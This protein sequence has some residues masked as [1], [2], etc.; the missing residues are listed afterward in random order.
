MK[1]NSSQIMTQVFQSEIPLKKLAEQS[2]I[3]STVLRNG[4][5]SCFEELGT[6]PKIF[7]PKM[8]G[9]IWSKP[10]QITLS[11]LKTD[12]FDRRTAARYP[13]TLDQIV[14]GAFSEANKDVNDMPNAALVRAE[15]GVLT[16][17]GGRRLDT[18]WTFTYPFPCQKPVGQIIIKAP[19]MKDVD[20]PVCEQS[21]K[22]GK[23]R[24]HLENKAGST[25]NID[26]LMSMRRNIIAIDTSFADL[27]NGLSFRLYRHQ[28]QGHRRYMDD[29]GNYIA[30]KDR[31]VVFRPADPSKPFEYYDLEADADINGPFEPPKSGMDGRFFWVTQKF[32]SEKTFPSGFEYVMMGLVS[33]PEAMINLNGLQKDLGSAPEIP[34]NINGKIRV[35]KGLEAYESL[36]WDMEKSYGYVRNAYGVAATAKLPNRGEKSAQL[37]ITVVTVNESK[38]FMAEARR[39]LLEAERLGFQALVSENEQWYDD[40]YDRREAGR[41]TIAATGAEKARID[42]M[43]L[44]D[45]Y[46]S[47]SISD[48]GHCDPDPRRYEGS[49]DYATFDIDTQSWHSLPCYNEIFGEPMLVRNQHER[50]LYYMRLLEAW[51]ETLKEKARIVYGLPGM[52]F[53]HGYLPPAVPDPWY[54]ECQAMDLC[55]DVPGQVVKLLWSIWDYLGDEDLLKRQVY[56]IT[57][58]LAIFYEAFARRNFDGRFYNLAPVVET[59]NWGISYHLKHTNNTTAAL[60]MFRKILNCAIEGATMLN[61]DADLIPGWREVAD[62]LAPYPKF[63]IGS[64]EIL[65]GNPGAMPRWAAGDHPWFTGDYPA[66]LADEINLDSHQADK[67]LIIRTN[68]TVRT[69]HNELAYILVGHFKDHVPCSY[70][71]P[72]VLID[73]SELLAKEVLSEKPERLL[74]S[75]SGRI[76]LFPVVPDWSEVAFRDMLTRGGFAVS[77]AK[78]RNGVQAVLIKARRNIPC[79]VMNP[80]A[81]QGIAGRS[82]AV[83]DITTGQAV[84]FEIDAQN[85]ECII[86]QALAGHEYSLDR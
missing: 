10:H 31:R 80:W 67:D 48:G 68:D 76:H 82:I 72:A 22:N 77:A 47:W 65:A 64:G 21:R 73:S 6:S 61:V 55:L 66:T 83:T 84:P 7:T 18:A 57:R 86:F 37:Y 30:K 23:A 43:V 26:Y 54:M 19:D 63:L 58:D 38:D 41:I 85:G 5:G 14:K 11:L 35:D 3:K 39:Q 46:W 8:K 71:N 17:E 69:D 53:G 34:V 74:N 56:P 42:A 4:P 20:Q 75:R 50:L 13:T 44:N 52:V 59:E 2:L 24:I 81:S 28:D 45:A 16:E 33:D 62:H 40:L 78:D 1:T 12:V 60:T 29:Q 79:Q 70:Y 36:Y 25:L 9:A 49:E 32:P 51:H 15:Y 27:K